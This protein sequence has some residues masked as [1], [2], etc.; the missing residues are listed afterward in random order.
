MKKKY[1]APLPS[2][3]SAPQKPVLATSK[4]MVISHSPRRAVGADLAAQIESEQAKRGRKLLEIDIS[5]IDPSPIPPRTVYSEDLIKDRAESIIKDGQIAAIIIRHNEAMDGRYIIVDGW[6]RVLAFRQYEISQRIW[7]EISEFDSAVDAAWYGFECNEQRAEHF[8]IDRAYF[9]QSL[10]NNGLAAN[11]QQLALHS[12]IE[13]TRLTKIMSFMK[14]PS[15]VLAEIKEKPARI[16]YNSAVLILSVYEAFGA[17][18]GESAAIKFV[19]HI[20]EKDLTYVKQEKER[21]RLLQLVNGQQKTNKAQDWIVKG[22]NG[23]GKITASNGK[24]NLSVSRVP[25]D[26]S[27]EL[28]MLLQET[29]DKFLNDA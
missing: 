10:L 26:K 8:D 4:A 3:F 14:L 5:L 18:E 29:V 1:E 22:V 13:R 23:V 28:Q 11:I 20:I 15:S 9:F 16:S 6:S 2:H 7:A 21:N 12:K 27:T 24:I 19:L 25:K 17:T